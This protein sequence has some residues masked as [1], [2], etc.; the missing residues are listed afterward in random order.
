MM[1]P[2][3]WLRLGPRSR[4]IRTT[5]GG[6]GW[7]RIGQIEPF[8]GRTGELGD[9]LGSEV[10][11]ITLVRDAMRLALL[12]ARRYAPYAKWLGTAFAALPIAGEL[13]PHL[14]RARHAGAWDAREAGI[15]AAMAVLARHQNDLGLGAPV[16]P[17]PRP[18]WSRPYTVIGAQRF[19]DALTAAITNPAVRAL[20][21]GLGG[22]DQ[23]IDSTDALGNRELREA[24]GGWL[25]ERQTTPGTC[26]AW[27]ASLWA[28]AGVSPAGRRGF[29]PR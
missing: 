5:S 29:P 16:D 19:A 13:M 1:S 3:S 22:I 26:Q 15:V 18:C 9:D 28:L 17:S 23:Y 21:A 8:V 4:G 12:Q 25:G 7:T 24:I 10:I 14:D 20:P 2:A 11:A 6:T 27:S